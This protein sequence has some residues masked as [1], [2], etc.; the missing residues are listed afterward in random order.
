MML[1]QYEY[2]GRG[3]PPASVADF[4]GK[5][6]RVAAK[7]IGAIPT[8]AGSKPTALQRGTVD[9]IG[10]LPTPSQRTSWMKFLTGIQQTCP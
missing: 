8:D 6:L 2:M 1:P 10:F 5:R 7:A 9:A 3:K 4:K